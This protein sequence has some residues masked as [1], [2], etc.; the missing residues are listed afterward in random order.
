[1][2]VFL[3]KKESKELQLFPHIIEFAFKKNTTIQFDSLKKE[4]SKFD[5]TKLNY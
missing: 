3:L 1:M 4:T 2:N 5:I